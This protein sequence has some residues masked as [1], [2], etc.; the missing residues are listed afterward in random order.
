MKRLLKTLLYFIFISTAS[1]DWDYKYFTLDQLIEKSS[2]IVVAKIK[3]IEE[4]GEHGRVSQQIVFSPIISLKGNQES[5][6]F[7]Y[8][9]SY[10]P[11]LDMIP[12]SHYIN[13]PLETKYLLFLSK[14]GDS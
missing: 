2:V 7:R 10:I 5:K 4:R 14:K 6:D 8:T 1:A 9:S 11:K 3:A 12:E 13:S